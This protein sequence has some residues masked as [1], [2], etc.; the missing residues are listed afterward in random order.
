MLHAL[1]RHDCN[2]F[3]KFTVESIHEIRVSY[4]THARKMLR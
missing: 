1:R 4:T 2:I 3:E